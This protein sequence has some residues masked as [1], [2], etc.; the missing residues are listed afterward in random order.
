MMSNNIGEGGFLY[1]LIYQQ[2]K[3]Y[4]TK[5][6]QEGNIDHIDSSTWGFTDNFFA[7]LLQTKFFEFVDKSYPTPR[8][9]TEVPIWFLIS[10]Q[11]AMRLSLKNAYSS[12]SELMLMSGPILFRVGFNIGSKQL[13]FNDKNKNPRKIPISDSTA[14]KFFK[15]TNVQAIRDWYNIDVQGWFKRHRYFDANGIYVL[16][17]T[18]CVVPDN[19]NYED[20]VKMPVDEHGQRYKGLDNMTK[21]Q[22]KALKYHNCYALSFLLHISAQKNSFHIAGY[23]WGPGNED[24]LPQ[25]KKIIANFIKAHEKGTIRLL[26]M[27]RGYLSGEY[28]TELKK[29][30]EIDVLIPLKENMQQYQDAIALSKMAETEWEEENEIDENTE[31]VL[32]KTKACKINDISLWDECKVKL[33][34]IVV[35]KTTFN[36]KTKNWE[37]N[38]WVLATTKVFRSAMDGA[39]SYNLRVQIEER[40]KQLKISWKLSQFSSPNKSLIEA[41]VCFILLTYSMIQAFLMRKDL[42]ELANKTIVSL[43]GEEAMGQNSV[44]T[45]ADDKFAV[46]NTK[47]VLGIVNQLPTKE[48]REK[49]QKVLK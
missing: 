28:I 46:Y 24:E 4:V 25:G 7:Y 31:E 37:T 39:R 41:Q 44:V 26:I 3:D 12:L 6:F 49:I 19:P 43:R 14:L 10:C 8:D 38:A 11:L 27:D 47:E 22:K 15:D 36:G 18:H 42:Q 29:V 23:E 5:K 48:V 40:N 9:K 34:T 30:Y 33:Q 1:P 20:A 13:G 21:E 35:E 17:Q 32:S 2:S 45:Y 16:D